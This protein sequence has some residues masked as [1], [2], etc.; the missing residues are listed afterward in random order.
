MKLVY[1]TQ[2][3]AKKLHAI[4]GNIFVTITITNMFITLALQLLL[5]FYL[6]HFQTRNICYFP[7]MSDLEPKIDYI[8]DCPHACAFALFRRKNAIELFLVFT[9]RAIKDDTCFFPYDGH[10]HMHPLGD[11]ALYFTWLF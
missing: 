2:E 6:N 8:E 10:W 7:R 11:I 5:I 1:R 4:Y 3:N 9:D